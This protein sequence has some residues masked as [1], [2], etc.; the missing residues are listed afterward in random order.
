MSTALTI[1]R[2][3]K[4]V[5][6]TLADLGLT[7]N[8]YRM[9]TFVDEGAPAIREISQRLAMKQPNV[10]TL[11]EGLVGRG[12][13]TRSR[14]GADARRWEL[15]LTPAG[16]ELLAEAERRNERTLTTV[17][18]NHDDRDTLRAGLDRW[19]PVLDQ[20]GIDLRSSL[21]ERRPAR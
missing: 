9:L 5:E 10:S 21:E 19:E 17:L 4:L 16:A 18:A 2:L 7:V 1:V 14:D 12:L 13:V 20:L 15:R 11:V 6:I 8:Q 3:S